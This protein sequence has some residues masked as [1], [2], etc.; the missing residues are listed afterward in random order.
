VDGRPTALADLLEALRPKL[1]REPGKP[2]IVRTDPAAP[3]GAAVAV[4]DELRQGR[5]A[6]GPSGPPEGVP[7][8]AYEPSSGAYGPSGA[9]SQR[10]A[11]ANEASG[12]AYQGSSAA[13]ERSTAAYEPS[14]RA[15][16]CS[17]AAN[18][19]P[20]AASEPSDGA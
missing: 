3:Y 18:K 8:A 16:G 4:L 10:S 17:G 5:N 13:Y 11:A 7:V 1:E 12:A 6:A 19:V 20:S 15:N 14:G 9:A 2:V